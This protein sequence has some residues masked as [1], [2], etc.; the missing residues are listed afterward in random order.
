[1]K[2][3][4]KVFSYVDYSIES[5]PTMMSSTSDNVLY[6]YAMFMNN[7]ELKMTLGM[8]ALKEKF[9]FRIRRSN[10]TRFKTSYK[11]IGCKFQL[12]VIKMQKDL[13]G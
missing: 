9:E 4:W 2:K 7:E 8:L 13:I 6:K 5:I 12:C 11:D 10:K 3:K 1:M